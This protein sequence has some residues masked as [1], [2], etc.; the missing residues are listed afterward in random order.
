MEEQVVLVDNQDNELGTCPKLKAHQEGLLHRALSVF[1]FNPEGKM[2]IHQR[3]HEK[4][5][6]GGMWTNACCSHPRPNERVGDAAIRRIKEEMGFSCPLQ[7]VFC[8]LYHAPVGNN[9]F[10]HEFDHVF[11]GSYDSQEVHPDPQEVAAYRWIAIPDLLEE[12]SH[13]KERFTPWFHL[14]VPKVL[15][16]RA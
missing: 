6:C 9:L 12:M 1:I 13:A 14:A 5:H 4:Y 3:A 11:I 16:H 15:Q 7:E 2:L 10:E 8:L